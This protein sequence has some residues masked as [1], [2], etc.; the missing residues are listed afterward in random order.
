M[1]QDE[2]KK[3]QDQQKERNNNAEFLSL[4]AT[5]RAAYSAATTLEVEYHQ[6]Q[7]QQ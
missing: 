5:C 7:Q 2:K 4:V 3:F 1:M 6:R